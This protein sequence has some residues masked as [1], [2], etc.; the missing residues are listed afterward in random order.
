M[1]GRFV[2]TDPPDE[3]ATYFSARL[4]IE[5][6]LEPSYNVAP[7]DDVY[8][9]VSD[10][11]TRVL[12]AFH[13][14][15]V[16]SWAKDPSV[17]SRMI[18]ARAETLADKAT[19]RRAFAKRR[20]LIPASGFYEWKKQPGRK[21]KQP[22]YMERTDG[23]PFAFAALWEYWKGDGDGLRSTTIITCPPND[24]LAPIHD[25]MPVILSPSA[26]DQWLNPE[27]DDLALL[28]KLLV[29]APPALLTARP[30]STQVNNVRNDG[31]ELLDK[32]DP[33]AESATSD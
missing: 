22:V 15:L 28:T 9:V 4:A 3:L 27:V 26:W 18:N 25:R 33:E 10:G 2:S 5:A 24:V 30:V 23:E 14:G 6:P 21:T 1:C 13:W 11:S 31:P 12:D 19:Y 29:P 16:P 17:G 32:F 7:T 8:V 20:C